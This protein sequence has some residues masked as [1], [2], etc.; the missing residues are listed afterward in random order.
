MNG[1]CHPPES[2]SLKPVFSRVI[3]NEHKTGRLVVVFA[4]NYISESLNSLNETTNWLIRFNDNNTVQIFNKPKPYIT[5]R[6]S[7][8]L[9]S[10]EGD[11]K[12]IS[13]S[14]KNAEI[15]QPDW[16]KKDGRGYVIL[17]GVD[18]LELV[19]KA[20]VDGQIVLNLS[21]MWTPKLFPYWIDY[22]KLTV[23]E[24]VVFDVVTPTWFKKPYVYNMNVKADEVIKIQYE[25]LPHRS[26]T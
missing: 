3:Y 13:F 4:S 23:N 16:I 15:L 17:S 18:K 10:T 11:F 8:Q 7:I 24:E 20:T 21:G 6:I 2:S 12:I 5:S 22:T 25:W 19:A 1:L 9:R 26:D 14:D